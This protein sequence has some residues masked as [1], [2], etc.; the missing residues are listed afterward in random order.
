MAVSISR[1]P[2]LRPSQYSVDIGGAL[3]N[4]VGLTKNKSEKNDVDTVD[5][6]PHGLKFPRPVVNLPKRIPSDRLTA[7]AKPR[8]GALAGRGGRGGASGA[9][10]SAVRCSLLVTGADL[11][12]LAFFFPCMFM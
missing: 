1:V 7:P 3:Q 12:E 4:D 6:G 11:V 9:A 10:R 8:A 2:L 5:N